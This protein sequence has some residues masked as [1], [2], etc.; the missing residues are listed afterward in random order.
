[1]AITLLTNVINTNYLALKL[2][3]DYLQQP[4][5]AGVTIMTEKYE[6][7]KEA[8]VSQQI[9]INS[10]GSKTIVNDNIAPKQRTWNV[11]G[12]IK[13]EPYEFS[14]FYMPSLARKK[15]ILDTAFYSRK[16]VQFRDKENKYHQVGIEKLTFTKE[17]DNQN[18][19]PVKF[20]LREITELSAISGV[21][22]AVQQNASSSEGSSDG[23]PSNIGNTTS[24][25]YDS[26]AYRGATAIG[27]AIGKL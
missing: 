19:Y 6:E 27:N 13:G 20:N 15:N 24:T 25:K 8:E 26:V 1:M 21:S 22:D 17:V 11:D 16:P 3:K 9:L 23:D 5:L 12:F 4:S 7:D 14:T 2:I 10:S 18:T